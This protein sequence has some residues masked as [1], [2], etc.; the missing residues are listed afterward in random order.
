VGSRGAPGGAAKKIEKLRAEGVPV[1]DGRV[2]NLRAHVFNE[3]ETERPLK[4]LRELQEELAA[5]VRVEPL[6]EEPGTVGGV[7]LSY[8]RPWEGVGAYVMIE[9]ATGRVLASRTMRNPVSF[10]YIPTYLAFR[11]LPVLLPLLERILGEGKQADVL[12]VDGSGILH[13]RSA[14]IAAHLGVLLDIPTIG[15]IKRLLYGRVDT[16]EMS[17]RE[18]RPVRDPR[19]GKTIGMAIKT[20]ERADPIYV[21]V[22]H[23]VD[24]NAAVRLVLELSRRKLPEPIRLAHRLCTAAARRSPEEEASTRTQAEQ[25]EQATKQQKQMALDL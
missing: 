9:R 25:A 6:A 4:K 22:G 20:A 2:A 21:S 10:P 24:L 3:F 16:R 13:H 17:A 18:T 1:E 15:V 7:D 14:G 5:R 11:E 12:M 8:P 19:T 23:R